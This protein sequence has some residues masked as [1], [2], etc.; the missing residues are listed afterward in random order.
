MC[1]LMIGVYLCPCHAPSVSGF[2][3]LYFEQF[4][5][6]QASMA[7]FLLHEGASVSR[8]APLVL[9]ALAFLAGLLVGCFFHTPAELDSVSWMR[10]VAEA[11]VSV[12]SLL[13][14]TLLPFLFS[15]F[16][17]Y[18]SQYWLLVPIAFWKAMS[19]SR[20][21]CWITAAYGSAGWLM[22]F[23]LMFTDLFTL[24]LLVLFWLRYGGK[25]RRLTA[26]SALLYCMVAV[27]IGSIDFWIISPFL[28]GL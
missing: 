20:V 8:R 17:V 14:V 9:L 27:A 21:A 11:P 15:A 1:V 12:V 24:P 26:L 22:R 7:R 16:A 2:Q 4:P 23:L 13:S 3:I 10:R 18:V 6:G 25:G 19:F 5:G 28:A